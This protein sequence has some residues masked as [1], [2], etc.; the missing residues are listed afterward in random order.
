M[1]ILVTGAAGHLGTNIVRALLEQGQKVRALVRPGSD[2]ESLKGLD[3]EIVTGDLGDPESLTR[4]VQ[5]VRQIYHTAA[6]ISIRSGDREQLM[7][8]NVGG[9]AA[10]MKAAL[11]A[12]VEKVVHTSSFGA[13]G[14]P[15]CKK[16]GKA[17]CSTEENLLDPFEEVMDYER[18]KAQSEIAVFQA[19]AQGLNVC[20]VNP[21][22]IVGP[23]DFG[24]SLVGRTIVDFG[25][26]KMKAYVP[27]AFDWVPM[28]DVVRGHLLAMEKG[29]RGE[30][31]LL[32]GQVHSL[33][34]IMDWLAEFTGRPRPWM[35]IPTWLMRSIAT[36]K[37]AIMRRFFPEVAPRFNSHS[38][39]LLSSGKHGSNEKARRELGLEPSS[40]REAYKEA[41]TWFKE[42]GRF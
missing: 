11:K 15:R 29:M 42:N 22:A 23:N 33:D 20:I 21:S 4:A 18:S 39:R 8:I 35:R 34:E 32:S 27:G 12:G 3:V 36:I 9:T 28:K 16:T 5:G 14:T 38:I 19:A 13:I 2:N 31:Y 41:V 7:H 26:G 1:T 10:L 40:V 25:L 17:L 37:D 30:R 6:M 24:P